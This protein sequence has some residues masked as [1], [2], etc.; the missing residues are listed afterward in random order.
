MFMSDS[1]RL[2]SHN[3]NK[4]KLM[5]IP[6][7]RNFNVSQAKYQPYMPK[8]ARIL[9]HLIFWKVALTTVSF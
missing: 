2:I 9:N 7:R 1:F 5:P 3:F 8:Q 4:K 6:N